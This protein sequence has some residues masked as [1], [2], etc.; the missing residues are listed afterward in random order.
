MKQEYIKV[1]DV[2]NKFGVTRQTVRNWIKKDLLQALFIDGAQYV[3]IGSLKRV[4]ST[5]RVISDLER[6]VSREKEELESVSKQYQGSVDELRDCCDGN[7]ALVWNRQT[8]VRFLPVFYGLIRPELSVSDR[9]SKI[10]QMLLAGDDVKTI[11]EQFGLTTARILQI[12][13]KELSDI[14]EETETYR[15]L[16]EE[17]D[18]LLEEVKVLKINARGYENIKCNMKAMDEVKP[19]ILTKRL[20]EFDLSVRALN[21]CKF[22]EI[23]TIADLVS[24]CKT[25]LLKIRCMGKKTLRELIE[26]VEG[27]GLEFGKNYIVQSDGSVL[28][29]QIINL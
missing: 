23:E 29:A 11:S 26:L 21:C 1:S 15:M 7:K 25:D 18:K 5:L 8:L 17:R 24:H 6:K 20:V 16:K 22:G 19:S 14:R 27:L 9:G 13:E 12:I 4:E 28:E 10:L 3:H 2:A